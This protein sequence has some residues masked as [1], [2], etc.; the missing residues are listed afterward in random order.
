MLEQYELD[1]LDIQEFN[2]YLVNTL[3]LTRKSDVLKYLGLPEDKLELLQK[4]LKIRE[5]YSF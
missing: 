4:Y 5:H 2:K 1:E 3:H